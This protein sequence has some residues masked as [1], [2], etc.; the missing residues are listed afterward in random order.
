MLIA[1]SRAKL[2][3]LVRHQ[4]SN[5]F[6]FDECDEG[7]ILDDSIERALERC[8]FCFSHTDNKYYRQDGEV[9][10]NP[11]QSAQYCIFLYYLGV[12]A[13]AR[14]EHQS[15]LAD[16]IYYLNK[17]L[18][19]ADLFYQVQLPR[20]F[21]LDHPLGSVMGRATYGEY[22]RFRQSCTVGNNHNLYPVIGTHVEMLAGSTI[23]GDCRI[24][25]HVV[26]SANT[27]VKDTEI[28]SH[29]VVF[30]RSPDLVIKPWAG[31]AARPK[32]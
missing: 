7:R 21:M 14:A 11:F 28:P 5:L 18:N 8:A 24:G 10:F 22:F 16:R 12:E 30:G 31:P 4:L 20:V 23:V 29:S 2:D 25:D 6:M 15:H 27:Y 9:F 32:R 17:A 26:I 3:L 13:F 1:I 19:G